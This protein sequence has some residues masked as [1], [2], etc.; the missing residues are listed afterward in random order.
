VRL[1]GNLTRRDLRLRKA[2]RPLKAASR[3]LV[4]CPRN[5]STNNSMSFRIIG[6]GT[7]TLQLP[8]A[9]HVIRVHS[10]VEFVPG[11]G[12]PQLSFHLGSSFRLVLTER[13][14]EFSLSRLPLPANLRPGSGSGSFLKCVYYCTE[15]RSGGGYRS[16]METTAPLGTC[17]SQGYNLII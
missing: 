16:A 11:R 7:D 3:K 6:G 9:V 4:L 14:Y 15:S 5:S 10:L 17:P 12:Q 13:R 2:G 8:E 1:I